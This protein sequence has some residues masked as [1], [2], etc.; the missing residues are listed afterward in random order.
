[1][2]R[3]ARMRMRAYRADMDNFLV[4]RPLFFNEKDYLPGST[5]TR[6]KSQAT[7]QQVQLLFRTG[8]ITASLPKPQAQSPA[9]VPAQQPTRGR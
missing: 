7:E 5:F 1:M 6:E 4:V 9:K 8:E 3:N 2:N